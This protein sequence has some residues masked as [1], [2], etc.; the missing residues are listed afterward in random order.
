MKM[1]FTLA[2][3]FAILLFSS[4]VQAQTDKALVMQNAQ[5][6]AEAMIRYFRFAEWDKYL[7]G[8]YPGVVKYYGGI[9]GYTNHVQT[10]RGLYGDS[11]QEN[12]ETVQILQ[13]VNDI[14]EWQCVIEK[15]R[16]TY[17]N[18]Q[19]AMIVSYIIGQ[20]K[21]DGLHWRYFDVSH[22]SVENV[23]YIMPDVFSTL[24]IP[25]RK[26]IVDVEVTEKEKTPAGSAGA[27]KKKTASRRK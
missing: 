13:L 20:S 22:N 21:D 5:A 9:N 11:L 25:E 15:R 19:K 27:T 14:D 10:A 23:I 7:A 8:S 18:G 3:L 6:G 26:V 24:A 17:S 1:P 4:T 2:T 16:E 12:P